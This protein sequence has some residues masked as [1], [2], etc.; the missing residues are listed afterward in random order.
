MPLKPQDI[1]DTINDSLTD[2][3]VVDEGDLVKFE[4]PMSHL[5]ELD[6]TEDDINLDFDL[7]EDVTEEEYKGV[8]GTVQNL[9]NLILKRHE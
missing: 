9:V 7:L 5:Y 3:H 4:T 6:Y 2:N 1:V 8:G